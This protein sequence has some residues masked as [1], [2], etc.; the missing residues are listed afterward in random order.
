MNDSMAMGLP[1]CDLGTCSCVSSNGTEVTLPKCD[2]KACS[3]V[4]SFDTPA[5]VTITCM[6]GIAFVLLTVLACAC[7]H[8]L[9]FRPERFDAVA[10]TDKILGSIVVKEKAKTSK[11]LSALLKVAAVLFLAVG[12]ATLLGLWGGFTTAMPQKGGGP[13]T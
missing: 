8:R 5:F 4:F 10:A 3:C 6:Y 9:K 13:T 12:P 7:L 11:I 2:T 1:A